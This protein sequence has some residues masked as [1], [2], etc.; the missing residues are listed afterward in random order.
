MKTAF[1]LIGIFFTLMVIALG[2]TLK[3]AL[4]NAEPILDETYYEKGLD[5]QAHIDARE[6]AE[7]MGFRIQG[8]VF[9]RSSL[10]RGEQ[11][12]GWTLVVPE[13]Q[14]VQAGDVD[15]KLTLDQPAT[16]RYRQVLEIQP[17]E[18]QQVDGNLVFL[19][20]VNLKRPGYWDV[21]VEGKKGE[22]YFHR[23]QRLAVQ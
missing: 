9:D 8:E 20:K 6:K 1:W 10:E 15:F 14:I 5:Y 11:S 7:A 21:I 12:I 2:Y 17:D 22:L 19:K 23:S 4:D 18:I 3:L 13:G 16:S